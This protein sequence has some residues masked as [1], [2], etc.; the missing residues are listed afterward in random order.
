MKTKKSIALITFAGLPMPAVHGGAVETLIDNICSHNETHQKL[1]IDVY[2]IFDEEAQKIAESFQHTE[3][4]YH[5]KG[6]NGRF[7]F[8][9]ILFKATGISVPDNT[10]NSIVKQINAKHYDVVYVTSIFRELY[11][12]I[13]KIETKV[14]WYLHADALTVLPSEVCKKI[15]NE[16]AAVVS[17][18]DFVGN[19]MRQCGCQVPIYTVKNCADICPIDKADREEKRKSFLSQY[20]IANRNTVFLYVGRITPIKG[21]KELVTAFSKIESKNTSL[22]IAGEPQNAAENEY[23]NLIKGIS[24]ERVIFIGYV[25]HSEL[26][27]IYN[28]CDV[29]VVPSICNEAAGLVILEAMMCGK[30]V[31]ATNRGGIPEYVSDKAALIDTDENFEDHLL[32][33]MNKYIHEFPYENTEGNTYIRT[34]EDLYVDFVAT[35]DKILA[36]S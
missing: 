10:M 34:K 29:L 1:H 16:C 6:K 11:F 5:S 4:L 22:I 24:D 33:A 20:N 32:S 21:I 18:S 30:P 31:I 15:G 17:V 27:E 25:K 3:Y 7:S 9:N 8:K 14:V 36:E 13:K 12:I 23:F 19:K 26:A 28:V 2:S 35:T